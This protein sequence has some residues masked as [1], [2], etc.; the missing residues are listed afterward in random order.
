MFSFKLDHFKVNP[1]GTNPCK[2]GAIC[3][4]TNSTYSCLSCPPQYTGI[5][6]D[7]CKS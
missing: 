2:N 6:C 5:N 1:C 4:P 7:T 3:Q